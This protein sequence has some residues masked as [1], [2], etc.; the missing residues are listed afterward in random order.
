MSKNNL[1]SYCETLNIEK[2]IELIE[3]GAD[4]NEKN[5]AG[6][7]PFNIVCIE[8][9]HIIGINHR[10]IELD[11]RDTTLNII[12]Y[13][14]EKGADVTNSLY[15][16]YYEYNVMKLLI[17]NGAK[18]N[19]E[20]D[21]FEYDLFTFILTELQNDDIMELIIQNGYDLSGYMGDIFINY[22]HII[23]MVKKHQPY[24]KYNKEHYIINACLS[25]NNELVKYLLDRNCVKTHPCNSYLPEINE[26]LLTY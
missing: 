7:T 26:L 17:K 18:L 15:F 14:I 8:V 21:D 20:I 19:S 16:A 4:V 3:N 12:K 1:H 23:P 22:N 9:S 25:D 11:V 24:F 13:M 6:K 10:K 5:G 2:I